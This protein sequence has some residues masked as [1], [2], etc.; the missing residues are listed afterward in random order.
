MTKPTTG[1]RQVA[2][3]EAFRFAGMVAAQ[4]G[5]DLLH[6]GLPLPGTP[7]W[8]GLPDDDAR[9]LLALLLGGVREAIAN[10]ARQAAVA[11]ASRAISAIS[12][13]TALGPRRP[14]RGPSY[15]PRKAG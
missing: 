7:L 2:W 11:D 1:S 4:H 10:D 14:E 13:N 12:T 6:D 5:I 15:I 8:C 3:F 9:K